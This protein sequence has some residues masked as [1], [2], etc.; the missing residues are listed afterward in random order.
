MR[1][2]QTIYHGVDALCVRQ[3][4]MTSRE[5]LQKRLVATRPFSR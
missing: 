2:A 4:A 5:A 1:V 3:A